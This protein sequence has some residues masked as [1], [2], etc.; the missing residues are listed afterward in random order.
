MMPFVDLLLFILDVVS[1]N[2]FS[3][4]ERVVAEYYRHH[5]GEWQPFGGCMIHLSDNVH[6]QLCKNVW[7]CD[8]L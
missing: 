7:E 6:L 2:Q 5:I 4:A 8:V 1:L 3:S